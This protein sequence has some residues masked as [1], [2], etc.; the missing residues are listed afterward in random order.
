MVG[1]MEGCFRRRVGFDDIDFSS[2]ADECAEAEADAVS[3][4]TL[5]VDA[6]NCNDGVWC[7]DIIDLLRL[8]DII[9]VFR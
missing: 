5:V 6:S 8:E 7:P 2:E 9:F 1:D 4:F 3:L